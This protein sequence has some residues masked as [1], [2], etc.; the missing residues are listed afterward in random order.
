MQAKSSP[1]IREPAWTSEGLEILCSNGEV[2]RVGF[3][4]DTC[5]R[6]VMAWCTSSISREMIRDLLDAVERRF[7]IAHA[8]HPI[9][10]LSDNGSAYLQRDPSP[11]SLRLRSPRDFIRSLQ[12]SATCLVGW[13]VTPAPHQTLDRRLGRWGRPFALKQRRES[14]LVICAHEKRE[15]LHRNPPILEEFVVQR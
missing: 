9:Q 11:Q 14:A 10:W 3:A 12:L 8:P 1:C 2:V 4:L 13:G 15:L 5:D 7:G 6:E